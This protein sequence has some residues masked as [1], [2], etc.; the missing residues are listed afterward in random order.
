M[1]AGE[2][3]STTIKVQAVYYYTETYRQIFDSK[4]PLA[5]LLYSKDR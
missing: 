3:E 2:E 1:A 4:A 5:I